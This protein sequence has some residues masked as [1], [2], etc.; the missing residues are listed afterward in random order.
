MKYRFLPLLLLL[1]VSFLPKPAAAHDYHA[2]IADVRF[3]PRTQH[4]EL[5]VKVFMD[6]LETALSQRNKTKV[7]YSPTSE[8]VKKYLSEYLRTNLVLE[9]EKGKP[10]K[11]NLLGSE[12]DADVVWMYLEVPVN[13]AS[14][15]QLYVKNALLTELFS[16][17]MNIVNINYKGKTESVMMQRGDTQ[18]KLT[19]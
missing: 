17:Q 4:L 8:Q 12:E 19:L 15:S 13:Q 7:V 14:L 18:K 9:V 3:N 16:D 2:S 1:F 6:D 10:L 5:A 11:Q